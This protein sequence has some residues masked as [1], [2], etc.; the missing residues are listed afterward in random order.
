MLRRPPHHDIRRAGIARGL[1]DRRESRLGERFRIGHPLAFDGRFPGRFFGRLLPGCRGFQQWHQRPAGV[2]GFTAGDR[3]WRA[4]GDDPAPASAPF[5]PQIDHPVGPLHHIEVVFHHEH[6]VA[7]SNQSL[8]HCQQLPHIGHVEAGRRFV[9]D[10]ERFAGGAFGQFAGEL[11][12]LRLA[13][14]EGG[15]GLAEMEVVEADITE[16]FQLAGDIG[17]IGKERAGLADLHAEQIGDIFSLPAHF[18]RVAGKSRAT[19]NFTGHPH[20]GEEI[21][22]EPH[23]AISLAGLAAAAGHVE[24]EAARLPA[25]LLRF[26]EHREEVADV[27]PHLHISRRIAARRAADR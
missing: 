3:L 5:G 15:G 20:I 2:R 25:P 1:R 17:G 9:E 10:V 24:A 8:E 12:P 22:I 21:H 11:H 26:G 16:R 7:G 19:A 13:A 18:E 14:G 4:F 23:R 6:G 27:V